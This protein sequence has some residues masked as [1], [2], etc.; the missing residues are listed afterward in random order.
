MVNIFFCGLAAGGF[1][2][3]PGC[4]SWRPRNNYIAIFDLLRIFSQLKNFTIFPNICIRI[5]IG[6]RIETNVVPEYRNK[7]RDSC[8]ERGNWKQLFD[9]ILACET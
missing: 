5:Q 4:P 3:T 1:S 2:C 9:S 7:V 8:Q 6:I